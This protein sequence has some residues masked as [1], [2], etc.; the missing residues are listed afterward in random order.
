MQLDN[1][2]RN[3]LDKHFEKVH[4]RITD[5]KVEIVSLKTSFNNHVENPCKNIVK[6]WQLE[7][8]KILIII[9]VL[10]FLFA[11]FKYFFE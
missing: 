2:D 3:Y 10:G 5:N 9:S 11:I 4:G 6:H 8:K 1:E 7:S